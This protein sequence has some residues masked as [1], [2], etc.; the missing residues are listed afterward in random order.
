MDNKR[1]SDPRFAHIHKDP[2][3]KSMSKKDKKI[4]VDKRYEILSEV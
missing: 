1:I 4:I 2:R 3:F